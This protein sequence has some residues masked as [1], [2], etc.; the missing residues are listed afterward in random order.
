MS[1]SLLAPVTETQTLHLQPSFCPS[2]IS[3]QDSQAVLQRRYDTYTLVRQAVGGTGLLVYQLD[4]TSSNYYTI[5]YNARTGQLEETMLQWFND[6]LLITM[7]V[8][9]FALPISIASVAIFFIVKVHIVV[10]LTRF[11]SWYC[12]H[13]YIGDKKALGCGV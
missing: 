3:P 9:G 13:I 7:N 11:V 5:S 4:D 8:L 1:L 6:G 2:Y 12:I 10:M